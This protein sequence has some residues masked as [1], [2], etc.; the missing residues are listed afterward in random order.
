M[1]ACRRFQVKE[2]AGNE[3]DAQLPLNADKVTVQ[4]WLGRP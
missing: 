4:Y 3:A 1:P 2:R